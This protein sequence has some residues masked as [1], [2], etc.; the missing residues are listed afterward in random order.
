ME[1][2]VETLPTHVV[3]QLQKKAAVSLN[4]IVRRIVWL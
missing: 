1:Q 2:E 3:V 4:Y